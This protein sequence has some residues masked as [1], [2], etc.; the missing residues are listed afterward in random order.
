V[1]TGTESMAP[2]P[3][4][5]IG[6]GGEIGDCAPLL[7]AVSSLIKYLRSTRHD[8]ITR[9][10]ERRH[11]N[12][13]PF[14][15]TTGSAWEQRPLARLAC[16]EN[17]ILSYKNQDACS[18]TARKPRER[19]LRRVEWSSAKLYP[20]VEDFVSYGGYSSHFRSHTEALCN[21]T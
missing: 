14:S 20:F 18:E 16:P 12:P 2:E 9:G 7:A 6:G 5:R 10:T 15:R 4:V 19:A 8:K 11:N 21:L 13:K 17:E 1:E 3:G